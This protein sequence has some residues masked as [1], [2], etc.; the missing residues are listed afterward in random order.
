MPI[1][2]SQNKGDVSVAFGVSRVSSVDAYGAKPYCGA[3]LET[4]TFKE[5][6]YYGL[7]RKHGHT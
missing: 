1:L 3:S 2:S 5:D 4:F 6:Y 7:E